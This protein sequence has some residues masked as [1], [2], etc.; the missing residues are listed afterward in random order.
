MTLTVNGEKREVADGATVAALLSTLDLSQQA[1]VV[2]RNGEIVDR[3]SYT[4]AVLAD[5]DTLELVRLVGGG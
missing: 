3:A 2:E 4:D 1:T 5:G